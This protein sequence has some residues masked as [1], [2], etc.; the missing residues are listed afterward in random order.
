MIQTAL[1]GIGAGAAGALLFASI[2]SGSL[3]SLVLF[4]LAPLPI[5]IA[6]LGW[7]HLAAMI[8]TAGAT[9]A[10]AAV[11]GGVFALAFFAGAGL[12]AWWLGYL[13]MLA[14]PAGHNGSATLEWYPPGR[15]VLWAASLA[16]ALVCMAIMAFG[17]DL[18][19]Y[20]AGLGGALDKLI[21]IRNDDGSVRPTGTRGPLIEFLVLAIPPAAAVLTTITHIFNLWL[22]GRVVKFSGLL[23]RPWPELPSMTFPPL[24]AGALAL[25]AI[26]SFTGG[27]PGIMCGAIAAA[28]LMAYGVLGFAVLHVVTRA[29]RARPFVLG[30]TYGAVIV[31]GWPVLALCLLGLGETAF[32]IRARFGQGPK[33]PRP[34]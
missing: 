2:A 31:F 21:Q 22:A 25:A 13:A 4:Y 27:L 28:L 19:S 32:G 26:G 14:R 9:L 3:L 17:M 12:P 11:F 29:V 33:P 34:V 8:A 18:E 23:K 10:L 5:M 20:R 1:F 15:I 7:T 30:G 16:A 6:A 24:A